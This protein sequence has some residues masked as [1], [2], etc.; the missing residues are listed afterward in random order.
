MQ[1]GW[2]SLLVSTWNKLSLDMDEIRKEEEE[3]EECSG[4]LKL[5][6]QVIQVDY[7]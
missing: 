7:K 1:Q 5:F 2:R 3:E 4:F 6:F